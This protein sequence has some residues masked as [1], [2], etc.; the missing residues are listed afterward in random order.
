[1][2]MTSSPWDLCVLGAGP[3]GYAAAMRAHDL[4]KRVVVIEKERIGGAGIHAG[5]LSSKTMWHLSNDYAVAAR[6]DRGYRAAGGLDVSYPMVIESVRAAV[7]ERRALLDRQLEQLT[8][9]A[10]NGGQV[11]LLRGTARFVSRE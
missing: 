2:A 4:G 9:P 11:I 10:D 1:M 6:T 7:T 8:T 5:A 3:A